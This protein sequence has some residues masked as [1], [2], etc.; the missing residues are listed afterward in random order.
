LKPRR[1]RSDG[2]KKEKLLEEYV[3]DSGYV[4]N[5]YLSLLSLVSRLP[6]NGSKV[7]WEA[8]C[9]DGTYSSGRAKGSRKIL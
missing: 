9:S 7:I 4:V 1:V 8:S 5:T 6:I 3:T 2:A